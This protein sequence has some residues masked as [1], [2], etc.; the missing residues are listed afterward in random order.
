METSGVV[1]EVHCNNCSKKYTGERSSK[2]KE[3][4]KENKYDG[5]KPRKDRKITWPF[6][7]YENHWS[8]PCVG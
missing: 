7:T 6:T 3:R 2:L 5:E 8:F 1:Y 4:M